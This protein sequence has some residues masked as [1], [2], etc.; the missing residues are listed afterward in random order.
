M[1]EFAHTE[2]T[3]RS[4]WNKNNIVP[5]TTTDQSS[6][7]HSIGGTTS[8]WCSACIRCSACSFLLRLVPASDASDPSTLLRL[9]H[10]ACAFR[11]FLCVSWVRIALDFHVCVYFCW[12][13]FFYSLK[14]HTYSTRYETNNRVSIVVIINCSSST[15]LTCDINILNGV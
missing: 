11:A 10:C 7:N 1:Y 14:I 9:A 4:H 3:S 13:L 8:N 12:I 2:H 15:S 5:N 6:V